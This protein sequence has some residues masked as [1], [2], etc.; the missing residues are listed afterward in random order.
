MPRSLHSSH[1]LESTQI[2][3]R[4]VSEIV[5]T[6]AGTGALRKFTKRHFLL[7]YLIDYVFEARKGHMQNEFI[8]TFFRQLLS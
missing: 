2:S 6:I 1:S 4:I 8:L 5:E 3:L 7:I